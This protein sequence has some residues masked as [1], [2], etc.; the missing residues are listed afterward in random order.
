MYGQKPPTLLSYVPGT[1]MVQVVDMEL[2]AREEIIEFLKWN[3]PQAEERM[4]R[5]VD[6]H[7]AEHHFTDWV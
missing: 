5:F 1:T 4:K 6:T 3:L 7:C 2:R